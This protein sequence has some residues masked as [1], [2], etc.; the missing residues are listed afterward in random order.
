MAAAVSAAALEGPAS[1]LRPFTPSETLSCTAVEL[2]LRYHTLPTEADLI[3]TR[4][5][6]D[7]FAP[8]MLP[9]G[10]TGDGSEVGPRIRVDKVSFTHGLHDIWATAMLEASRKPGGLPQY[11]PQPYP[12]SL[13]SIGSALRWVALGGEVTVGYVERLRAELGGTTQRVWVSAYTNQVQ[14]YIPTQLVMDE[15]GYEGGDNM[16]SSA[17][18]V[19]PHPARLLSPAVNAATAGPECL[20]A[21]RQA[22]YADGLEEVVVAAVRGLASAAPLAL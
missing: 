18:P 20:T 8:G 9:T 15:G 4:D 7:F 13:W 3:R 1:A 2:P 10:C 11:Q 5:S 19:R 22:R 6:D 12:L 14:C 17:H 16:I 21:A